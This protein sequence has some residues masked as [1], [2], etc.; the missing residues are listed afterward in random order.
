MID[1]K[2]FREK[3]ALDQKLEAKENEIDAIKSNYEP[4]FKKL[5]TKKTKY[6]EA[7][8]DFSDQTKKFSIMETS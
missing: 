5:N 3:D 6:E 4:E 8:A 1:I 7:L 2:E